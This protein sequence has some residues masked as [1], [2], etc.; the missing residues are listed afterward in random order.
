MTMQP[1][2]WEQLQQESAVW[3]EKNFA[4][5]PAHWPLL[6]IVEELGELEEAY[7]PEEGEVDA[8]AV[9]DA[10]ADTMVFMADYCNAMGMHLASIVSDASKISHLDV[11]QK[12]M[13]LAGRLAHAQLKLEQGIRG[14]TAD[15]RA[16]LL[17]TLSHV[18]AH[19]HQVLGNTDEKQSLID[20]VF[21]TWKEV[22]ER[23]WRCQ[24]PGCRAPLPKHNIGKCADHAD[25]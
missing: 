15:H 17:F 10:I 9:L 4:P 11:E 25:A 3:S 12:S 16:A 8:A 14:T 13:I 2:T 7:L 6:G 21:A 24:S 5:R 19:L 1:F 20:V 18:V 23:V 22:R